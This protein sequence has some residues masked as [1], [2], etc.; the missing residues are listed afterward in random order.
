MPRFNGQCGDG[1]GAVNPSD[2]LIDQL[3]NAV[4]EPET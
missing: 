4:F 3:D 1:A 2:G